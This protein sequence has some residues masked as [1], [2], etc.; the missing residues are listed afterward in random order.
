MVLSLRALCWVTFHLTQLQPRGGRQ[1]PQHSQ[2]ACSSAAQLA[3]PNL[4][5]GGK[6]PSSAAALFFNMHA[7]AL[8]NSCHP[9]LTRNLQVPQH[10]L[11]TC[12][13]HRCKPHLTLLYPGEEEPSSATAILLDRYTCS[14]AAQLTSP[15]YNPG[16]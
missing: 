14:T 4:Y 1:V 9:T 11:L 3:S 10:S 8:H 15:T 12:I 6:V 2:Y 7:A 16:G 13:Q 5:P